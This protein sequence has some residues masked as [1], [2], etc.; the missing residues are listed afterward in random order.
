MTAIK[1]TKL[2]GT[3]PKNASELLP[4]TTAQT[5]R[6]CKLYSG[7]LI[8]YPE[9]TVVANT[10][11]TGTIKTLYGMRDPSTNDLKWLSWT[12]DVDIVTPATDELD[13]QRIYYTGDGAPKVSTYALATGGAPPYPITAYDLGLPLPTVQPTTVATDFSVVTIETFERDG[14]KGGGR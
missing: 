6:N 2:M 9:A 5:A 4:D 8:P 11:R 14:S 10:D 12:T 13:E 7:D 3:A 1:I